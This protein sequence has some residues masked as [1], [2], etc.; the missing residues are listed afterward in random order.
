MDEFPSNLGFVSGDE[1]PIGLK[2]FRCGVRS[3]GLVVPKSLNKYNEN[4]E[5]EIFLSPLLIIVI[6]SNQWFSRMLAEDGQ[7][8]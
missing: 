5:L 6:S 1:G 3:V 7:F 2:S 8:M 4:R